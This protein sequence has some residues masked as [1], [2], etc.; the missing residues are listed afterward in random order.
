MMKKLLSYALPFIAAAGIAGCK[1]EF[2]AAIVKKASYSEIPAGVTT[3]L[4]NNEN[5]EFISSGS[6]E[7]EVGFGLM[8]STKIQDPDG[9]RS[10]TTKISNYKTSKPIEVNCEYALGDNYSITMIR[11]SKG[12]IRKIPLAHVY[13]D[14]L[15]RSSKGVQV[16]TG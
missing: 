5:G 1:P 2:P 11:P 10:Y 14:R 4:Y 3:C 9:I 8:L 16:H 6:G 12:V 15:Q 7:N 13:S